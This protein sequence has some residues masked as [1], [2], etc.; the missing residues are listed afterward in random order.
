MFALRNDK[1]QTRT[2]VASLNFGWVL[3]R[4]RVFGFQTRSL[5]FKKNLRFVVS[6]RDAQVTLLQFND[7][8]DLRRVGHWFDLFGV[9][10]G[11]QRVVITSALH[12]RVRAAE[13]RSHRD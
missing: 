9:M 5:G 1:I 11:E 10:N 6:G 3:Y 2:A 4:T 12:R 7:N 13:L 8:K